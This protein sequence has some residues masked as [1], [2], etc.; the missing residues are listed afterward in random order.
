MN[1]YINVHKLSQV[2]I[3]C[4]IIYQGVAENRTNLNCNSAGIPLLMQFERQK[5][6]P[7]NFISILA[8]FSST[9]FHLPSDATEHGSEVEDFLGA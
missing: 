1:D 2:V 4:E 8:V 6:K 7:F 3:F 9:F 5:L